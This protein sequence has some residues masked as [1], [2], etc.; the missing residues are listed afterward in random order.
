VTLRILIEKNETSFFKKRL[1]SPSSLI[2][3]DFII[4]LNKRIKAVFL[5]FHM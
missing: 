2:L 1:I 3:K 4:I 5:I